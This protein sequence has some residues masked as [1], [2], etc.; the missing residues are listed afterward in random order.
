MNREKTF[1]DENSNYY[2]RIYETDDGKVYAADSYCI[3][4]ETVEFASWDEAVGQAEIVIKETRSRLTPSLMPLSDGDIA[5]CGITD[6]YPEAKENL[7]ALLANGQDFDTGWGS[8]KKEPISLRIVG[9]G[10]ILQV[11]V[12]QE[13]DD[14]PE[15][16]DDALAA[17]GIDD[18][19]DLSEAD[20]TVVTDLII[21]DGAYEN[22]VCETETLPRSSSYE[23]VMETVSKLCDATDR[24]IK[25][26]F[27]IVK[28]YVQGFS[29]PC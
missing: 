24:S 20:L 11:S 27:D 7:C 12:C 29:D 6:L 9:A 17:L 1:V 25:S 2:I 14:F 15:I 13:M 19:D 8:S 26:S 5:H 10:E 22:P 23:T 21:S 16:I 28:L 3:E 4:G 18:L